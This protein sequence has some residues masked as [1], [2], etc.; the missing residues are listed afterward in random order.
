ML[1][2]S[3]RHY[4]ATQSSAIESWLRITVPE[5]ARRYPEWTQ[6]IG[7]AG[8]EDLCREIEQFSARY[9]F[10]DEECFWKILERRIAD[11]ELLSSLTEFQIFALSRKGAAETLRLQRFLDDKTRGSP[12]VLI[13]L[14]FD[15]EEDQ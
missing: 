6:Q 2:V 11:P 1:V 5:V 12:T 7:I 4:Q 3:D 13:R 15:S 9:E 8:V 10:D 14:G